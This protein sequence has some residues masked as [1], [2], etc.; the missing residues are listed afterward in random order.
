MKTNNLLSSGL[1]AS[2]D[3]VAADTCN[4]VQEADVRF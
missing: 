3:E 2:L 4:L 1:V